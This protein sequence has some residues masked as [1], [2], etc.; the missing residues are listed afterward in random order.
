MIM[1][2]GFPVTAS[3]HSCPF[4]NGNCLLAVKGLVPTRYAL[5]LT[6]AKSF[7][8]GNQAQAA[9]DGSFIWGDSTVANISSTANNQFVIRSAGGVHLSPATRM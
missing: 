3:A 4:D 2:A 9:H 7:A 6:G 5:G 1:L 8:A